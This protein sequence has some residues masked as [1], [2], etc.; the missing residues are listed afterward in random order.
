MLRN[1]NS[2]YLNE[3][4]FENWGATPD[5]EADQVLLTRDGTDGRVYGGDC[6]LI[7]VKDGKRAAAGRAMAR[8]LDKLMRQHAEDRTEEQKRTQLLCPGCF[9]V[10]GFNMLTELARRNGQ[11]L[12]EL[13]H[14]MADAFQKLADGGPDAIEEIVVWLDPDT[15]NSSFGDY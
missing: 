10:V 3:Q 8:E 9:M 15:A 11:P 7:H 4:Y 2:D 12:S 6:N 13:A 5:A 1:T 14:S